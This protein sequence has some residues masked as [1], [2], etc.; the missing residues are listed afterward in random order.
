MKP[1]VV[2]VVRG[3]SYAIAVTVRWR[4]GF[5]EPVTVSVQNLPRG[6]RASTLTLRP[7]R[8]NGVV[9]ILARRP[10][11]LN[12]AT[13]ILIV[14]K[15]AT[16][17]VT[18]NA[19]L[20]VV[21]AF[22][23]A[24]APSLAPA[25]PVISDGHGGTHKVGVSQDEIGLRS[26]FYTDA[27]VVH[28]ANQAEL[29][30]FLA[31]YGGRV[32]ETDAVP[33]APTRVGVTVPAAAR[34]ATEYLVKLDA[35][36]FPLGGFPEDAA[37][38]QL[39]S[40]VSF[41]SQLA[42]RVMA[43]TADANVQGV[44]VSPS[45]VLASDAVRLQTRERPAGAG[46]QDAYNTGQFP[47]FQSAGSR[48]T[49]TAA[50]TWVAA[51]GI[52]RR[53]RV[54]VVDGGFWL[55]QNGQP[56]TG[57]SDGSDFP[58]NPIQYDFVGDDYVAT[59]MNPA[60]CSGGATCP[61]HGNRSA[62]VAV[63]A[64]N[65]SAAA[66][67]TGGFVGDPMLFQTDI[68][69][70]VQRDRAVRTAVAWGA[71]VISMSFGGPC[72]YGC[73]QDERSHDTNRGYREA[74]AAGVVLVAAAGNGDGVTGTDAGAEDAWVHPCITD[75]V[76]CVGALND[77]GNTS[78]A[79]SNYGAP[80]DIWAPTNIPAMPDGA[81]PNVL[82]SHGGTS[83]SAPFI[84]GIAAMMKAI[85]PGLTSDRVRDILVN[86]AWKDSSDSKVG[87][88]VNA[89]A[90]VKAAS[91]DRLPADRFE[92]NDGQT[93]ATVLTPQRYDDLTLHAPGQRD[94]YRVVVPSRSRLSFS[95]TTS[96][97]LGTMGFGYGLIG[98]Q[99][100]GF[101]D[102]ETDT[103]RANGRDLTVATVPRGR[104]VVAAG[105]A[106]R[107]PYDLVVTRTAAP[108]PLDA[109]ERDAIGNNNNVLARA[110][111]VIPGS[112]NATISPGEDVDFYS[113][114]SSNSFF[115]P[116]LGGI[117]SRFVVTTS[118]VPLRITLYDAA[119]NIVRSTQASSD[120]A[121]QASFENLSAGRFYV[122][123]E[124]TSNDPGAYNFAVGARFIQ[125]TGFFV[126]R[127]WYLDPGGPVERILVD[128]VDWFGF[129]L[130][131]AE[132]IARTL[133]ISGLLHIA[134]FNPDGRVL[135]RGRPVLSRGRQVGESMSLTSLAANKGYYLKVSRDLDRPVQ[136]EPKGTL[137]G[138][139][140]A[141]TF[142]R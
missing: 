18:R 14:G 62:G 100:C 31:R 37:R 51:H 78:Q 40:H 68:R 80:L 83:A 120:C 70:R 112:Y 72:N 30:A 99:S 69:D 86:T 44:S 56:L 77:N 126:Q 98:E 134:I 96:D 52:A 63:G 104:Y 113:F 90:A 35:S 127:P 43:L 36:T 71:D 89:L 101:P 58:A 4:P 28:P 39:G 53:V 38:A 7:K 59:G 116:R 26:A 110:R 65:N 92:P 74:R 94:F 95:V 32:I 9:R 3:S 61:W 102:G 60:A 17:R 8:P 75:G 34:R 76:I 142:G 73:R 103:P 42:A 128:R 107:M 5:R 79:Y 24:V 11:A 16:A 67:G 137:G 48:A 25:H 115:D 50:W 84:A 138:V 54:A 135:L 19:S 91:N 47:R 55:N 132:T 109:L 129:R 139:S 33:Q 124:S 66:A 87:A 106:A 2:K 81:N 125:G 114:D 23:F 49:V 20:K 131:V 97:D 41:S 136:N 21:P 13:T 117:S 85:D 6:T 105:A 29:Q 108:L 1:S 111:N 46:F 140:Y 119:G 45:Y 141:L 57:P 64:A 82:A 12:R 123:V 15:A 118:D 121:K 130:N 27:V 93:Q 22:T 10:A 122:K 88:Y 133:R